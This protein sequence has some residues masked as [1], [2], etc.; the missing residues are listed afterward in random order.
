[1]RAALVDSNVVIHAQNE[2]SGENHERA[3]EIVRAIDRGDLPSAHVTDY[4]LAETLNLMHS[5]GAHRLGVETYDLLNE[6]AAFEL[7]S[8][9]TDDFKAGVDLYR[10]RGS[11]SLVDGVLAAYMRRVG[12]EYVY[13]FDSEFDSIEW[14]TRLDVAVNPFD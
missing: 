4:V 1:M 3:L 2:D 5:R 11:L 6:S 13:S 8:T 14:V 9:A 7:R 12:L 10:R